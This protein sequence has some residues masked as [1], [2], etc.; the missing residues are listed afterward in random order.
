MFVQLKNNLLHNDRYRRNVV[1]TA[2]LLVNLLLHWNHWQKDL[3]SFH[4]WRQTQTQSNI[5][6]FYEEDFNILNPRKNDRGNEAGFFRMEFPLMQWLVAC[7]YKLFGSHIIITRIAMFVISLFTLLGI[8]RLI[9]LL[10]NKEDTALAV[11]WALNFSP[12]F[13]YYSINPLPDNFALCLGVWGLAKFIQADI[14]KKMIQYFLAGLFLS[15]ST[16]CK[17][18]FILFFAL[19]FFSLLGKLIQSKFSFSYWI[20][21]IILALPLVLP[22][23]WYITVIPQ[24]GGA[25]SGIVNG[26]SDNKVPFTT[27]LEYLQHNLISTLPELLLNY[28]NALFF[29]AGLVLIIKL[30]Y[31][32][33]KYFFP[34]LGLSLAVISYFLYEINMIVKVHDYYLFPFFPLLFIITGIGLHFF[35][36]SKKIMLKRLTLVLLILLP[37]TCML[38]LSGRWDAENPGFNKALLD[39]KTELQTAV[40][41]NALC[42]AGSDPTHFVWFYY[43][44]KKGWIFDQDNK[45]KIHCDSLIKLGAKYLYSDDTALDNMFYNQHCI[46]KKLLEKGNI[47]VYKLK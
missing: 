9:K 24:W 46:E 28:G 39:Y 41:D 4:V 21:G 19:P 30:K 8:Y 18:P 15:L 29:I 31:Y 38:R 34:F 25:G 33:K 7:L 42:I 40:P 47:K 36:N 3:M 16:L 17:L 11:T 26:V 13:F 27:V 14:D 32:K 1:F 22:A 2:I 20:R 43:L 12:T 35:L 37:F 10:C 45:N 6:N 5:D 44:H 23:M